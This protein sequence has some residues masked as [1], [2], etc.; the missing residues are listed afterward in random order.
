M[1]QLF[2]SFVGKIFKYFC[3]AFHVACVEKGER[4]AKKLPDTVEKSQ[5]HGA[6]RFL[7]LL[8]HEIN[9]FRARQRKFWRLKKSGDS[10]KKNLPTLLWTAAEM[11]KY[12]L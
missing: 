2:F 6:T 4:A 7:K 5:H 11:E 12:C 1:L 9:S 3:S 10:Y 8:D